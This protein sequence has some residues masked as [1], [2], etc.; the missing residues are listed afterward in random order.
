MVAVVE[1]V[2]VVVVVADVVIINFG[3]RVLTGDWGD[4]GGLFS[5]VI[6]KSCS[7]EIK[8]SDEIFISLPTNISS[9]IRK[10][11]N[12]QCILILGVN[13]AIF[14]LTYHSIFSYC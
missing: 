1:V 14:F 8:L 5:D 12:K 3:V 13:F 6:E 2:V 10:K 11:A 4:W 7:F 9:S